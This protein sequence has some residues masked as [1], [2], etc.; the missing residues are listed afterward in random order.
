[1]HRLA[2][3]R[4]ITSVAVDGLRKKHVYSI[5]YSIFV[6]QVLETEPAGVSSTVTISDERSYIKIE[7]V[8]G[9]MPT[10]IHGAFSEVCGEFTVDRSTVSR[11]ANC[12]HGDCVSLDNVASMGASPG[13][14]SEKSC[15]VR[16]AKEGL[17][18][19]L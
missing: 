7:T 14:V 5:V 8:R 19:E 4:K 15:D 11:W 10:D 17:E 2:V 16:E 9:K 18:N 12:F 1:M 3:P 6:S 13:E